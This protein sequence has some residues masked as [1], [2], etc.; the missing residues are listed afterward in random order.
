[1]NFQHLQAVRQLNAARRVHRGIDAGF[2][3]LSQKLEAQYREEEEIFETILRLGVNGLTEAQHRTFRNTMS[4]TTGTQGGYTV[5]GTVSVSI[6]DAMRQ[7]SS[8]RRLSTVLVT[9]TGESRGYPTSDGRSE[10]GEQLDQN[11]QSNSQDVSFGSAAWNTYKYG[12]KV[13]TVPIEL[14]QDSSIDIGGFL[15][16]RI[17]TR[18][19]RITNT[20]FTVGT[21]TGEPLGIVPA[22][23]VGKTGAAGQTV[24]VTPDDLEDLMASVDAEYR[25]SMQCAWMMNDSTLHAIS[26]LKDTAGQPL[27]LVKWG[28]KATGE[29]TT[30]LGFPVE[31]NPDMPVMAAGAK[32]ILF[33]DFSTYKVRDVAEVRIIRMSDSAFTT[34]GQVGFIGFLRS[35]GTYADLGTAVRAYQNSA[36]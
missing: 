27:K 9:G 4:T 35:G 33:G 15:E 11:T 31:T 19:G 28:S 5:P 25:E 21:G 18:I 34:K 20:K 3:A 12:S 7:F 22:A 13:I 17:A 26:K 10:V 6:A 2:S 8:M 14:I 16:R 36:S 24:T 29:P 32:S 23:T 30:L 1:M